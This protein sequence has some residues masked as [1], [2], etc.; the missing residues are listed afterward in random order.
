MYSAIYYVLIYLFTFSEEVNGLLKILVFYFEEDKACN[1]Q[2]TFTTLLDLIQ[3][4]MKEI[5]R[6]ETTSQDTTSSFGPHA[7]VQSI[8]AQRQNIV[9]SADKRNGMLIITKF[10]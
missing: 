5:W 7:T 2:S 1:L 4:D 8:L 3:N 6:N 9:Y 10:I